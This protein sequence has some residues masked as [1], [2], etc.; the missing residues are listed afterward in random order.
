MY[1]SQKFRSR[2]Q[3]IS[4]TIAAGEQ[5]SERRRGFKG[6]LS[7]TKTTTTMTRRI[8]IIDRERTRHSKL[9]RLRLTVVLKPSKAWSS[10]PRAYEPSSASPS[11]PPRHSSVSPFKA[12]SGNRQQSG[13]GWS[14]LSVLT[15][16]GRA[17]LTPRERGE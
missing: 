1:I 2:E 4:C 12:A 3:D 16:S 13:V 6:V 7:F 9:L 10:H 17:V 15:T 14:H 11:A 8:F 5:P